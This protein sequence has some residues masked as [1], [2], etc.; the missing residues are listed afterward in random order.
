MEQHDL[1]AY[2]TLPPPMYPE[3]PTLDDTA[4]FSRAVDLREDGLCP[5]ACCNDIEFVYRM[6]Q[7]LVFGVPILNAY[8]KLV[9]ETC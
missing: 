1:R 8:A 7:Q 3:V 2:S 6:L 5:S 4:S 9:A